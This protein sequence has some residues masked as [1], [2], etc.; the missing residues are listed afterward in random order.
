VAVS[1]VLAALV[2][3]LLILAGV[4]VTARVGTRSRRDDNRRADQQRRR[5]VYAA[6]LELAYLA[7]ALSRKGVFEGGDRHIQI[8]LDG[9]VANPLVKAKVGLRLA[10][11]SDAV[12]ARLAVLDEAFRHFGEDSSADKDEDVFQWIDRQFAERIQGPLSDLSKAMAEDLA[13]R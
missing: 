4:I 13:S 1:E 9:L 6:Y 10:G 8:V 5:D 2:T 3:G 11:P 12:L 7:P